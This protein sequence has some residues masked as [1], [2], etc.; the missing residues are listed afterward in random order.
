MPPRIS[1]QLQAKFRRVQILLCDV[2][3][4]LTDA[5]I[6][7]DGKSETKRFNVTDGLGLRLLR[8]CGIRVGWI[9][10]R[11]SAATDQRAKELEVDFL[12]QTHDSKLRAA[13]EILAQTGATWDSVC[14]MGD[15][16]VDLGLLNRAGVA[17]AVPHAM[18][19]AKSLAHYVTRAPGGHGAVREVVELILK[20]QQKWNRLVADYTTGRL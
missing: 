20:A 6:W 15:D 17:V 8:R 1:K 13:E 2:D 16:L 11:C 5:A 4:I 14:F 10:G 19:E 9:S 7:L 3:G 18:A 12:Y